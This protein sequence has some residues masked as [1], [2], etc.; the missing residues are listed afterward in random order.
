[1]PIFWSDNMLISSILTRNEMSKK[2][3]FGLMN[4]VLIILTA[5]IMICTYHYLIGSIYNQKTNIQLK[6]LKLETEIGLLTQLL[7]H[8]KDLTPQEI[9]NFDIKYQT[10]FS[11]ALSVAPSSHIAN[12]EIISSKLEQEKKSKEATLST[13]TQAGFLSYLPPWPMLIILGLGVFFTQL[14]NNFGDI[15]PSIICQGLKK[16]KNWWGKR[17]IQDKS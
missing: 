11:I 12:Q 6:K 9:K 16:I 7:S 3:Y 2:L 10:N 8:S 15:A 14:I 1:M 13:I 17:E 5:F 4:M